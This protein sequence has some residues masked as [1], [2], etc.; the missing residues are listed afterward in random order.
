[1]HAFTHTHAHAHTH[2]HT[3]TL[4]ETCLLLMGTT[5]SGRSEVT[6]DDEEAVSA[7][8]VAQADAQLADVGFGG[9][10][11]TPLAESLWEQVCGLHVVCMHALSIFI[12]VH[13]Y[14]CTCA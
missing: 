2:T 14:V 8:G 11:L 3:H 12:Y 13:L 6:M 9:M 10:E 7:G 4:T 5:K 1:M